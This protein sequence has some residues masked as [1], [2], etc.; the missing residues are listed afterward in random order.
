ME[1]LRDTEYLLT[2]I[3]GTKHDVNRLLSLQPMESMV[4]QWDSTFGEVLRTSPVTESVMRHL[5]GSSLN[6][7]TLS[8]VG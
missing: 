8:Q 6:V 1:L 5:Q 4:Y 2:I 3:T 7:H